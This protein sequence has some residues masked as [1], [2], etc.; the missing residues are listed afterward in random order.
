[1]PTYLCHGFRW[2]RSNIRTF[3]QEQDLGD[4]T[5]DSIIASQ[6]FPAIIQSFYSAFDFLPNCPAAVGD[7][8]ARKPT[9]QQPS[10]TQPHHITASSPSPQGFE[11]VPSSPPDQC[12]IRLL[13]EYD[14]R[15]VTSADQPHVFVADHV[16]RVDLSVSVLQEMALY[17]ERTIQYTCGHNVM[18]SESRDEYDKRESEPDE[19][20]SEKSQ[21]EAVRWFE[22]L[23]VELQ[24]DE[25]IGW[26]V[27]ICRD[28]EYKV[29][30]NRGEAEGDNEPKE[31]DLSVECRPIQPNHITEAAGQSPVSEQA[32]AG[33]TQVQAEKG[34]SQDATRETIRKQSVSGTP[35]QETERKA[36]PARERSMSAPRRLTGGCSYSPFPRPAPPPAMTPAG[37]SA[38]LRPATRNGNLLLKPHPE[39]ESISDT[40]LPPPA[41]IPH[42]RRSLRRLFGR[43]KGN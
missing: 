11:P 6:S 23:R 12:A 21:G 31:G 40:H 25:D 7:S 38:T 5:P 2:H 37:T 4:A 16:V 17:E 39:I 36:S 9:L 24:P 19:V 14:A 43:R 27:V 33:H 20:T 22:K 30:Q 26:Y 34:D 32:E 13:E 15:G 3:L 35:P 41:K 18:A 29:E 28:K 1:M 42:K 10:D 8:L